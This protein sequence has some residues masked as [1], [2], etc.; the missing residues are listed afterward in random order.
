MK[1]ISI[2]NPAAKRSFALLVCLVTL[3]SLFPSAFSADPVPAEADASAA[4]LVDVNTDT[5]LYEKNA[6]TPLNPASTTKIMTAL[7]VFEAIDSGTV[8]LTDTVTATQQMVGMLPWDASHITPAISAG[9]TL[10]VEELLY[11]TL[12]YSD[13]LACNLLAQKVSGS[14]EQFVAAMNEKAAQLGCTG[15][16]F[17]NTHGYTADG[18]MMTAR[19]LYLI[20]QAA[21]QHEGFRTMV[22]TKSY[23][24]PA[25]N[26]TPTRTLANT[27]MLLIDS[28]YT[29]P[30]TIGVKTGK[31]DAA[32]LCLS[33]YTSVNGRDLICII[34]GAKQT[35]LPDGTKN[36]GHFSE[37]KRLLEWGYSAYGYRTIVSAGDIVTSVTVGNSD[38]AALLLRADA[39]ITSLLPTDIS[40]SDITTSVTY[41]SGSVTAPVKAG[42]AVGA[43]TA[44]YKGN[45]IGS[46][47]I[48]AASDI[49][50]VKPVATRNALILI[51]LGVVV[52]TSVTV[53]IIVLEGKKK[54]PVQQPYRQSRRRYDDEDDYYYED[55]DE[56]YH[57]S[58][59]RRDSY[60]DDRPLGQRRRY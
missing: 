3:F 19:S 30:G 51:L 10:T 21:M 43:V 58:R 4:L 39:S 46:T 33:A 16:T 22:S 7:L 8:S 23:T 9:E 31:T 47:A 34:M 15:T 60:Y 50:E 57:R 37:A 56:G 1:F 29:L 5:V 54:T 26:L 28:P 49:E 52:L 24:M 53:L 25:T 44:F 41:T 6:D 12:I 20:T 27:N 45:L 11:S 2:K 40:E 38:N 18:H 13:C 48:C 42:Q 59:D 32:G 14:I 36:L 55:F 35:D 17:V